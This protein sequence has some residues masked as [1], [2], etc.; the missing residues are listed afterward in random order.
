MVNDK[1]WN[2]VKRFNSLMKTSI[3]GPKCLEICNGDCCSIRIDVPKILAEGYI[4]KGFA[5]KI[6]FIRGNV[7]SFT[8]RFDEKKGK[9]F[10]Y[11]KSINGCLVHNSGIKP[12]QCWI[13][14]T[15]FSNP[16]NIDLKCKKASGWKIIDK[17]NAENAKKLLNQYIFLCTLEAKKELKLIRSR[18]DNS[19]NQN[20][21]R[22]LLK[23]TPPS[24]LAG[25]KD[26]W[27]NIII[28]PAQGISLQ[29]KN[30]C[31]SA[32]IGCRVKY[33]T[34]TSI[35]DKVINRL[36]E[37]LQK[38]LYKYVKKYGLD[39]DGEYSFLKLSKVV[40]N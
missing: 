15:N 39:H 33:L 36:F 1:F 3:E 26:S 2:I 4:K 11:D 5:N 13:Y 20:F 10:L 27:D 32:N 38:N 29:L 7:F 34:C 18:L 17:K 31:E 19:L 30:F 35:C 21:L 14:P 6:D 16:E 37:F 9:C 23:S 22:K 28:L 12:P 8:L 24:A 40:N 25:F